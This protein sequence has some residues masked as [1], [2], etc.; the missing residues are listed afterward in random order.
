[1]IDIWTHCCN[2]RRKTCGFTQV[3]DDFTT[4]DTS[5]V[6]FINQHGFNHDKDLVN[7]GSNKFIELVHDSVNHLDEQMS[8]LVFQR[9]SHQQRK[10]LIKQ[11]PGTIISRIFSDLFHGGFTDLRSPILDLEEESH[12]LAFFEFINGHIFFS[13]VVHEF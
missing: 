4:F 12:D 2:H 3:T 10:N 11:R 13:L 6:I 1:M 8:F 5:I 7:I 9:R